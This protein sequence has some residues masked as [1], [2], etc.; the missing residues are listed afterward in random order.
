MKDNARSFFTPE[1]Q[2]DL[3]LA[4]MHAELDTSGEIRIHIETRCRG[5]ANDRAAQIFKILGMDKTE[6]RNGIL[7]YLALKN[8]KFAVIGD[9]GINA[10]VEENFWQQLKAILIEHFARDKFTEGLV[11]CIGKVGAELK[12]YFPHQRDD[13]NE[14]TDDLS[15]GD[16]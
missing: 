7:F 1:Q 13:I 10:M 5:E 6:L 16:E 14:L 8:R 3:K 12:K 11:V 15:F 4:I 2:E 9:S